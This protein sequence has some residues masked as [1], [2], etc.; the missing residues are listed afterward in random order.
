MSRSFPRWRFLACLLAAGLLFGA[1][2]LPAAADSAADQLQ[3]LQQQEAGKRATLAQLAKDQAAAQA[4]LASLRA[5]LSAKTADLAAIQQQAQALSHE[6]QLESSQEQQLIADH[7]RHVAMFSAQVRGLYKSGPVGTTVFLFGAST[8]SDLLDRFLTMT[9]IVRSVQDHAHQLGIE[10]DKLE[11][12][13]SRTTQLQAALTPLLDELAQQQATA[14]AAY[15]SQASLVSSIEAGQRAALGGLLSIQRQER[16]LE[17]ALAAAE[18]AAAAAARKGAGIA[19]AATC[20]TPPAGSHHLLRPR[21]GPRGWDVPVRR[22]WYGQ[23]R[24]LVAADPGPL[25]H[26]RHPWDSA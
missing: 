15:N 8:F 24:H 16:Q 9:H 23:A 2:P 1:L 18:A 5:G 7:D 6:I 20:P 11:Q 14:Q 4:A 10:R 25:L 12:E 13:R 3:Q 17:Q 26:R 19:Y 21:L 22:L